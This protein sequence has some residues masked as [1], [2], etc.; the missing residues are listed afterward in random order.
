M[1]DE[2]FKYGVKKEKVQ[3]RIDNYNKILEKDFA[4]EENPI[5]AIIRIEN[6]LE[7]LNQEE[8]EANSNSE[9]SDLIAS[10]NEKRAEFEKQLKEIYKTEA[11]Y[12]FAN[13]VINEIKDLLAKS[14]EEYSFVDIEDIEKRI[15]YY[16]K[17]LKSIDKEF[18][19]KRKAE[20]EDELEKDKAELEKLRENSENENLEPENTGDVELKFIEIAKNKAI[21]DLEDK[22]K[23]RKA[24][25][26][27]YEDKMNSN[28]FEELKKW[29][30]ELEELK[31][32]KITE[33][34]YSQ[35]K[36]AEIKSLKEEIANLNATL[37]GL[38]DDLDRKGYYEK[39]SKIL[40]EKQEKLNSL[41]NPKKEKASK[42]D[43]DKIKK[44]E[45][46]I[47]EKETELD[48]INKN[49]ENLSNR[50]ASDINTQ[51]RC[52][53]NRIEEL[54]DIAKEKE[55]FK[56]NDK[57][58]IEINYPVIKPEVDKEQLAA[59]WQVRRTDMLDKYYGNRDRAE[60]YN[61]KI[62]ILKDHICEKEFEF[63]DKNGKKQKGIYQTIEP[64]KGMEKD[65]SFLQLE[66]YAE[67]LERLSKYKA[68]D[69]KAYENCKDP[70]TA[71]QED[72]QYINTNNNAYNR[73]ANTKNNL[74]TLG[75]Y[76]EKVPYSQMQEGQ[77]FRNALR[78]I[79]NVGKFIRNHTTAPINRFVGSKIVAPIY[80]FIKGSDENVAGLYSNKRTHRY[81]ARRDYF[82]SQGNGYF[83]SRIKS[84]FN[85]KEG[86][87]AVL[88]AG[89]YDI[90]QSVI[91]KYIDLAEKE[92]VR[93]QT[94]FMNKSLDDKIKMIQ[95]DLAEQK[96]PDN[97]K[98]LQETLDN[99]E[100]AKKQVEIDKQRNEAR[101]IS[102][103]KQTD[104]VDMNQHDIANKENVNRTITGVK[105]LTRFGIRKF[106]GPKIKE[107]LIEHSKK[108]VE[109]V[110]IYQDE[111]IQSK[112]VDTTYKE[113]IVPKYKTVVENNTTVQDIMA[114][115]AGK[116]VKGYYSVYGGER[117]PAMYKL[118]GKEKITSIF[119]KIGDK[120]KGLS[121]TAGLGAPELTDGT[122]PPNLL[123]ANGV[124]KQ[125]ISVGSLL[126][127]LGSNNISTDKL[128]DL[129]VSVGDNYWVKLS[130]LYK[131]VT[132][133][134]KIGEEIKKV[135]DVP[136]H[137]ENVSALVD[138][139][140]T[141][142][143]M[144]ED[145]KIALI[146]KR[147]GVGLNAVEAGLIADDVYEN[148]R[149]TTTSINPTKEQP[150][151]YDFETGFTGNKDDDYKATMQ[152]VKKPIKKEGSPKT[153]E[154]DEEQEI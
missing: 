58:E 29:E 26:V 93:K 32:G 27:G 70:K 136:G 43:D 15:E 35:A 149:K 25:I 127:G 86:N 39:L 48:E 37:I 153:S 7:K 62:G 9:K 146:L 133:Q 84:I 17:L 66:E 144:L 45:D 94:E 150:R 20:L 18:L 60:E 79:G 55:L 24:T 83:S 68:G 134:V 108:P 128:S 63:V 40:Q 138:K 87:K 73:L 13:D 2:K 41:L 97:I 111:E 107:W 131:G 143:Q 103:V 38:E 81:V 30:K 129:Y 99:L 95:T 75:K 56:I 109:I 141:V 74:T 137:M 50:D 90:K 52:I 152:V 115:N 135:V 88:S 28:R 11:E 147:M 123:D 22:I 36:D 112:W 102:Q 78:G 71:L 57:G 140:R 85:A 89:A 21:E 14:K 104:A 44:L 1:A 53:M 19:E 139:S 23:N 122:F 47:K 132:K 125:D 92:S 114:S 72:E 124:L 126:K 46:A 6:E 76:G 120:G 101:K 59:E 110:E 33:E 145:E 54:E 64:Y 119:K 96:E 148:A 117:S 10:I 16:K 116:E 142:T 4:N 98:K 69:I 49:L 121:D 91:R 113:E 77:L 51:K 5:V 34:I 105:M 42:K 12:I 151:H 67:K 80:G 61:Y 118:T 100:K 65:V 3:T 154:K 8:I 82:A 106:V 31:S 130:D